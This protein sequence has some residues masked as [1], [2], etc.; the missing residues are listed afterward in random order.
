M[1]FAQFISVQLAN[2]P[3]NGKVLQ[4][5]GTNSSWV[6]TSTLGISGGGGSGS[7]IG[8]TSPFSAGYLIEATGTNVTLSN[9]AIFQTTGGLIGIGTTTPST[10]LYVIGSTTIS[11]LGI[12][13]VFST[14]SGALYNVSTTGTGLVVLQTSPTLITPILGVAS[15]T[16]LT[17]SNNEWLTALAQTGGTFL[18]VNPQG[19]I[20]ATTSPYTGGTVTS[21]G[22]VPVT[23]QTASAAIT[24]SGNITI[25]TTAGYTSAFTTASSTGGTVFGLSTTSSS[26]ILDIPSTT[27]SGNWVQATSP[28]LTTP[29]LGVASGTSLSLSQNLFVTGTASTSGQTTLTTASSTSITVSGNI[30]ANAQIVLT[31][32]PAN[33]T[34]SGLVENGISASTT[35]GD[36]VFRNSVNTWSDADANAS[37]TASSTGQLGLALGT[38]AAGS[39]VPILLTG[40]VMN[41]AWN[42]ATGTAMF[43]ATSSIANGTMTTIAPTYVGNVG[44]YVGYMRTQ[45]ILY[46]NPDDTY[47]AY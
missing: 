15:G 16:A 6:A 46:F 35:L 26:I 10:A 40:Y 41:G 18:A 24:T 27:G 39:G 37:S 5:D 3:S 36:I 17:L 7:G 2:S 23:G 43:L 44:R 14:A 33:L 22:I 30:Y 12:G 8:T 21:V 47:T 13:S 29:I 11:S 20:V 4:T 42:F 19:L 9:S 32:N 45:N 1:A 31:P 25:S 34:A 38:V 28:S